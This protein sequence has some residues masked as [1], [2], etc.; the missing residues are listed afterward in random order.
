MTGVSRLNRE[1]IV[2]K[3]TFDNAGDKVGYVEYCYLDIDTDQPE[4]AAVDTGRATTQSRLVP[5]MDATMTTEGLQVAFSRDQIWEAPEL[6]LDKELDDDDEAQLFDY[7]GLQY[8]EAR[9][10]TGL[11]AGRTTP[12]V[13]EVATVRGGA[14]RARL[15]RHVVTET[16]TTTVPPLYEEEALLGTRA[17][18]REQVLVETVTSDEVVA[19]DLRDEQIGFEGP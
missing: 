3:A 5:L 10:D 17:V 12:A 13:E 15:R 19:A 9:S 6:D 8:S 4:W 14:G 2:G 16:V 7:Y 18:P 1:H 11:P